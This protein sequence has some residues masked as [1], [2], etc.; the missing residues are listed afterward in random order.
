MFK[1][2]EFKTEIAYAIIC[3]FS[4]NTNLEFHFRLVYKFSP[5]VTVDLMCLD[6]KNMCFLLRM[7]L[8]NCVYDLLRQYDYYFAVIVGEKRNDRKA[9]TITGSLKGNFR[10]TPILDRSDILI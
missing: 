2:R 10:R 6:N 7:Q 1:T 4:K 9:K 5:K 3:V 8:Y